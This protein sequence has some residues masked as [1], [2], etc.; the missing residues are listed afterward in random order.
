M[1]FMLISVQL[2]TVAFTGVYSYVAG[3]AFLILAE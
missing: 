3:L 1:Q 2:R